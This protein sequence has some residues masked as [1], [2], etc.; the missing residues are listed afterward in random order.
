VWTPVH[1]WALA[2]LIKDDYAKAG[3][4][5]LPVVKGDKHTTL[6]IGAYALVTVAVSFVPV[7]LGVGW[8]YG[9]IALVL[10]GFLLRGC[11][12]LY[13]QV[14]RPRASSLFHYSMIYLALLFL[15]M[16]VDASNRW[17]EWLLVSV[18]CIVLYYVKFGKKTQ[19]SVLSN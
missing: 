16:S 9:V 2:I 17:L 8:G 3:V 19:K 14:D 6:Q 4:P 5:M 11:L 12:K 15:A 13:Q 18:L 7:W 1:F 10:N